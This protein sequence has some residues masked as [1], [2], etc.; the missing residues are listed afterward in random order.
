MDTYPYKVFSEK[1]LSYS[2][3]TLK[4]QMKGCTLWGKDTAG[5]MDELKLDPLKQTAKDFAVADAGGGASK[6]T[7][8][9]VIPFLHYANDSK[10]VGLR[11]RHEKILDSKVIVLMDRL[12][13]NLFQRKKCIRR[14]S[15]IQPLP[16]SILHDD[17]CQE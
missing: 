12:Q 7:I 14:P 11:K 13:L 2:L 3:D 8:N 5:H 16:T 4:T 6:V 1:L 17:R 15:E 10:K 9:A